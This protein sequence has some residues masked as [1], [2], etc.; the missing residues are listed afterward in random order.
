MWWATKGNIK[1]T[2]KINLSSRTLYQVLN[3][4]EQEIVEDDLYCNAK[5][6]EL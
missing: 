6:R 1:D 2:A 4:L 5:K 3:R